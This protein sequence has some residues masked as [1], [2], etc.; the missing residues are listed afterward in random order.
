MVLHAEECNALC[1]VHDLE[2]LRAKDDDLRLQEYQ[3]EGFRGKEE[4]L[5]MRYEPTVE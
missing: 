1:Q 3:I 5:E 4:V 2:A